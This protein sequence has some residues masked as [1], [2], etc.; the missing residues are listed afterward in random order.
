MNRRTFFEKSCNFISR[1]CF[2]AEW[3]PDV[4]G[5]KDRDI[6]DYDVMAEVMKYRKIDAHEHVDLY[7]GGPEVQIDFA[8]RLG[9]EKLV[10]SK[11][12]DNPNRYS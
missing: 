4:H 10:V 11:P 2:L 3:L 8:D 7:E 6:S 9:I 5:S 12:V 1:S